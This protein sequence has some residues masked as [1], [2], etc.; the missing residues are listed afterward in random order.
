M[1]LYGA[2]NCMEG[3][4]VKKT[5]SIDFFNKPGDRSSAKVSF[6]VNLI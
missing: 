6:D 4:F 1:E 3:E 2:M 5:V